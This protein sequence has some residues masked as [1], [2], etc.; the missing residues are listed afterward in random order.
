MNSKK[1]SEAM[2]ELDSKYVDE[3]ISYKKKAKKPVWAK[4]GAI[5]ACF[6]AVTVL[7]VGL[8]QSGLFGSHTDIA[9]LNN[10]EKI[11]FVKS[12]NV[13]GS[14]A[15]DVDVTT[16]PLTEDETLA[17]FSDLPVTAN[18]IFLNSDIDAGGSQELIGFEGQVGNVKVI[19]S[20]SDVQLLDTV[21]V[22]TEKVSEING[23]TIVAGYFVTDPNSR[24]EQNAIYYATFEIGD[25]KVYLENGGMKDDSETIK[26]QLAEVIQ[27]LTE[28]G[29]FSRKLYQLME[30]NVLVL[31]PIRERRPTDVATLLSDMVSW[32]SREYKK[33]NF[34]IRED[35]MVALC[36]Y[37]WPK[38]ISEIEMVVG[39]LAS[40]CASCITLPDVIKIGIP[41]F[42]ASTQTI[43]ELEKE[44]IEKLKAQGMSRDAIAKALGIS[45]A[46]LYRKLKKYEERTM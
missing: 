16:K 40:T 35:A 17:L 43:E 37:E 14:L 46:T 5:A 33:T 22:G 11:V 31:Q 13:G 10:G 1:F 8:F 3:A 15:L 20:T 23:I 18:A 21:I 12:D 6:V 7:G 34:I 29:W 38:N 30:Q 19:I 39:R 9:T 42:A 41:A 32:F 45:R 44:Q 4:W 26:N 36:N 28:N 2:S 25:C 24:G 27:K